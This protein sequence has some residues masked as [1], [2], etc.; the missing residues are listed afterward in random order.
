VEKFDIPVV[1]FVFKRLETASMVI[2]SIRSV[3][4]SVMYVFADGARTEVPGEAEKVQQVRD[5]I[6][7][8]ID[9]DCK[10]NLYFSDVNKGCDK[11]IRDGVDLVF[12]EQDK[13]IILEDDAVPT[14]AFFYYC[15]ELLL[16]YEAER[17]IQYI[18][19]YNAVG[20]NDA[21]LHNYS[22]GKSVP[23]N[24]AIA[25]WA[26]RW[27]NCDFDMKE[28]PSNKSRKML[29]D[30]FFY[31]ELK[32]RYI[33]IFDELYDKK[34]TSWDYIFEHD[35][36]TKD[37]LA[38]VPR[39][40]MV[41]SFGFAEGA[42][43]PQRKKETERFVQMM[44]ATNVE[45]VYPLTEKPI[46]Q[47]NKKYDKLRQ[48]KLLEVRG[49]VVYRRLLDAYLAVKE[50]AYTHLPKKYWNMLKRLIVGKR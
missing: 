23:M 38:V 37:R 41:T 45:K 43:H 32:N 48:W 25:T 13:A 28:W 29:D 33:R 18:A 24:G 47:R 39:E 27:N 5:Y 50:W 42:Y 44:T 12:S 10:K 21:I 49:G 6:S 16:E 35:M 20:T 7:T 15:R 2:D 8:A 22:F 19:G 36:L 31:K 11:N 40:N 17:S 4:P 14:E 1:L 46:I 3:K 9:W 34:A 26:D 30:I